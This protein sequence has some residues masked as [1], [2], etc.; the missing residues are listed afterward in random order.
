MPRSLQ[1]IAARGA[2]VV[3]SALLLATP[4]PLGAGVGARRSR[5]RSRRRFHA[6]GRNG[7]VRQALTSGV[8]DVLRR[9]LFYP[10]TVPW[11]YT[12]GG[13]DPVHYPSLIDPNSRS[14]N[15][16]TSGKTAYVYF[17]QFHTQSCQLGLDRDLVRVPVEIA[18]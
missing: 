9:N 3:V 2:I 16:D 7:G 17:T 15:F 1:G 4:S 8:W 10:A 12:C 18:P 11:T 13:P 5:R 6:S 14:R